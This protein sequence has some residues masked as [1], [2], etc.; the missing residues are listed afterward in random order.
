M[1]TL[2]SFFNGR[3]ATNPCPNPVAPL[4]AIEARAAEVGASVVYDNGSD[5]DAA[6]KG[7]RVRRR[8]GRL[9][10]KKMGEFQAQPCR[11]CRSVARGDT[12]VQLSRV[13]FCQSA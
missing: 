9:R 12:L 8:R 1:G 4:D 10:F 6:A 5:L 2:L 13:F 7:R 3:P 11:R